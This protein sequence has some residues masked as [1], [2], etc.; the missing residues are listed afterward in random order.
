MYEQGS[1]QCVIV[2]CSRSIGCCCIASRPA[3]CDVISIGIAIVSIVKV[4]V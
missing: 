2:G 1:N 3:M 4:G